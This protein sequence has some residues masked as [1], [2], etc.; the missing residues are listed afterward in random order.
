MKLLDYLNKGIE[1]F[2]YL[3]ILLTPLVFAGN[4]HE[5]FEFNKMWLVFGFTSVIGFMWF[6]KMV[7]TKK[8]I[9]KRTILDIP[10]FLFLIANIISTIIS[11]DQ[12]V[13][14]WGYYTR[15]NGGLL[16]IFSYIFLYYAFVSNLDLNG[17]LKEFG[18]ELQRRIMF[19]GGIGVYLLTILLT[20]V[21]A[22]SAT[23]PNNPSLGIGFIL[24]TG[25]SVTTILIAL[26]V[27]SGN[28]IERVL[29]ASVFSGILVA[30]WALP[31]HFGFD[32]TCLIFRGELNVACWTADF[33]PRVRIFGTLGQPNWLAG[34]MG[35]YLP[36]SLALIFI[37]LKESKKLLNYDLILYVISFLIFYATLLYT[38]STS[39]I[40]ASYI[41]LFVFAVILI[42]LNIKNLKIFKNG[43][44][45]V[46]I[47]SLV[48]ITFFA[49]ARLPIIEK[50]SLAEVQ[51]TLT[52][53]DPLSERTT[54]GSQPTASSTPLGGSDS[55]DIRLIVWRGGIDAWRESP[56]IGTGVDTF[57]FA[58]YKHRPVE[59]NKLSEWNFLYNKAHNEYINYLT[60]TGVFGLGTY[61]LFIFLFIFY[62]LLNIFGL[63]IKPLKYFQGYEV[64]YEKKIILTGLLSSFISMLIINFFG[65]SVVFLN[66]LLFLIPAFAIVLLRKPNEEEKNNNLSL[67]YAEW[68]GI[69]ILGL[70]SSGIVIFLLRT[71]VADTKFALGANLN[72]AG[73]YQAAFPLLLEANDMRNEPIFKD[74]FSVNKAILAVGYAQQ[75]STESATIVNQLTTE[76]VNT[77]DEL[78]NEYPNNIV[79]WKTRIRILYTLSQIDPKFY[80]LALEA[81]QRAAELA[82]TDASVLY[83]L[84]VLYGQNSELQP[85]EKRKEYLNKAVETLKKVVEYKPDYREAY[86]ALGLFYHE[87]GTETVGT[88]VNVTDQNY[89]NLAKEQMKII[90]EKINPDDKQ[91]KD[92]LNAWELEN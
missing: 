3:L 9:F 13:S 85:E 16:S 70:I 89:H 37:K 78:I 65:F 27:L 31:S 49:G 14:L 67:T 1:L 5:L 28:L 55:G 72:R 15:W 48:G 43:L 88:T 21:I 66:V 84:G 6:S 45:P 64:T 44:I 69:F 52:K 75:G 77:S 11:L 24:T 35:V 2:F 92:S 32:P 83:N 36:I 91:A 18:T 34:L 63:K 58:Y 20:G 76:A 53:P 4:T 25:L 54:N 10:I 46:I 8:L 61:L 29:K 26:S 57:A 12:H 86:F 87:L 7:I 56:I 60:T 73:E 33:Q 39:G 40:I 47:I 22:S 50:F 68:S 59:H 74:E 81:T 62:S 41:S 90:L 79:F 71:W 19:F 30:I 23:D 17:K 38:S 42:A 82:P 51:K 80:P